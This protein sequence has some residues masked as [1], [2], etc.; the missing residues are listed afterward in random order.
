[1][2]N[3]DK[4]VIR[5]WRRGLI[6]P[7]SEE[8]RVL[9]GLTEHEAPRSWPHPPGELVAD[10]PAKLVKAKRKRDMERYEAAQEREAA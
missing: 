7:I 6:K 10:A 5:A 8:S 2:R 4:I 3:I 1:M 9:A